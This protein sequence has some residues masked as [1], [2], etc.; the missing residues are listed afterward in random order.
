VKKISTVATNRNEIFKEHK[1]TIG[2]DLGDRS[3]HYCILDEAGE[4]ILEHN[5]STTPKGIHQVFNKI[6]RSRVALRNRDPF[7]V[8]QS[9]AQ[10]VGPRSDRGPCAQRAAHRGEQPKR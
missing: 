5:F 2:L 9:A 10:P 8:G 6:P 3:S 1:L 7:S 4:V